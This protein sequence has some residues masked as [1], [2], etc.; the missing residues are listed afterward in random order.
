MSKGYEY[1]HRSVDAA[2][3]WL[4]AAFGFT[5]PISV[6]ANNAVAI[7]LLLLW[8]YKREF[9]QTWAL[10][11]NAK[12]VLAVM[13]FLGLH[14]V[15]LLWT[16]DMAWGM[17]ML[18]K[19]WILLLLPIMMY[20]MVPEHRKYYI[21]AFLLAMTLSELLSYL[22]WLQVIPPFLHATVSDP[23]PFM[24]HVS[25]NPLLAFAI[26]LVGYYVLFDTS[27]TKMQKIFF[28][29]F[30]VTMSINMFITGGRAGQVGYVTVLAILIYQYCKGNT[31]KAFLVFSVMVGSIVAAAYLG[32]S[33]F[34]KRVNMAVSEIRTY[35]GDQNTSVGLRMNFA[36][37][38]LKMIREH[39]LLGVGTG[40]FCKEYAKINHRCTPNVRS[41]VQPHNM[42]LLEMGMFGIVGLASLLFILLSQIVVARKQ[43]DPMLA[44][45][46]I[47]LPLLYGVIM[48]SDSYLLGHITTALFVYF[49]AL[50]YR[51]AERDV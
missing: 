8:L 4:I 50:L 16:E 6:A 45:I 44:K 24:H 7:L 13:L 17:H 42:Y 32:S 41:T 5:L 46:G 51:P 2:G 1:R 47:A 18:R 48:L 31:L 27:V 10:V 40:D 22:V 14:V 21:S 43:R 38:T 20:M 3:S 39:P 33:I 28:V 19:Q 35:D 23:T 34:Q 26:Y 25:Y 12:V 37:N 15:G 9:S 36:V 11:K 29:L 49:S 30:F